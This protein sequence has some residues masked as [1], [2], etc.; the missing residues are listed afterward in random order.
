[1]SFPLKLGQESIL[2]RQLGLPFEAYR[3]SITAMH[4][5]TIETTVD[6]PSGL[7]QALDGPWLWYRGGAVFPG[8]PDWGV[9]WI[10]FQTPMDISIAQLNYLDLK[11]SGMDST[12]LDGPMMDAAAYKAQV[13]LDSLP[14]MA[15]DK[16]STCASE[17]WNYDDPTCWSE[18]YPVCSEG[19]RQSPINIE[20]SKV[21]RQGKDLFLPQVSWRPVQDLHVTNFGKGLMVSS[22]QLGY[23]TLTGED[24]FPD[25]FEVAQIHLHMPSEHTLEGETYAAELQVVH[26]HQKTVVQPHNS[27]DNFPFVT[28]SFFFQIGDRESTLLKQMFLPGI[29]EPD[30]YRVMELPLDL[31]RHLGPALDGDFYVYEGSS[32]TPDCHE[33]NK[34][35]IFDHAFS[36]SMDQ[37]ATF[38]AMFPSPGNN[39]PIQPMKQQIV[40]KNSFEGGTPIYFD[41]YLSRHIG[42]NRFYPG[43]GYILVPI[44]AALVLM[45]AV[46]FFIFKRDLVSKKS[47]MASLAETIGLREASRV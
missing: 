12:R 33:M 36:M 4:S 6:L 13:W 42:R 45:C 40:A 25:F 47:S 20:R 28:T 1:M 22:N 44:S 23:I 46:M 9:R 31:A 3:D 7:R 18:Q 21:T 35:F 2:L 16:H 5:Y 29:M 19:T 17:G 26:R 14:A 34:W 11:V 10:L 39:R 43:E 30:T 41:F 38:K 37:W 8:C 32:T 27:A 15:V 24:G